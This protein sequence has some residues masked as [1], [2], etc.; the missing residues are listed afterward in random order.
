M[1]RVRLTEAAPSPDPYELIDSR[2]VARML[3]CCVKTV[4][5]MF[6]RGELT[7]ARVGREYRTTRYAVM[8]DL[9]LEARPGSGRWR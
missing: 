1:R 5:A 6:Q 7:F 2:E 8:R 3:G 9:G 4:Y